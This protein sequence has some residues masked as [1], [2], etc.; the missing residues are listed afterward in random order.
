MHRDAQG[1]PAYIET[2]AYPV[3]DLKGSVIQVIVY[4]IDVTGQRQTEKELKQRAAELEQMNMALKVL[5]K[6]REQD[7][8]EI[9]EKIFANFQLTL[10]PILYDLEKTLTHNKQRDILKILQSSLKNILSPFSK[11]LSDK[12]I[13]LTPTEIHVANLIKLGNANKEIAALLNCSPNTISRHRDN[14]RKKTGLKNKKINLRSFL[15][16][17][18]QTDY[19]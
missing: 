14:I 5:L 10:L 2:Y 11:K 1:N 4:Q 16:S 15:L 3:L 8:T 18:E 17:L 12:M 7:K 19:F 6:R 13:L 9:E